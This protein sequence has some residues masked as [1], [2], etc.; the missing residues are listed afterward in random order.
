MAQ[1]T[2]E[3]IAQSGQF[4]IGYRTDARP[5]SFEEAGNATG[6]AVDICRRVALG[7]KEHLKLAEMTVTYVPV[8]LDN[9]F[10]AVADGDIDIECADT[11]ITMQRQERVD[12]SMMTFVTGGTV[13]SM[14][15]SRIGEMREL[16]RKRVAA[17]RGTS[18]ADGLQAYLS[19]NRID[20]KIT[21]VAD[22][23]AGVALLRSGGVDAFASDQILL[24]GDVLKALEKDKNVDFAFAD[25]LFSFEPYGLMVR[26]N[27]ADFR[28]VV[29]RVIAQMFRAG[30]QTKLYQ[31][32]VG[33]VGV[34]PSSLLLSMFQLQSLSE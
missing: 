23:D 12:F 24:L 9:R 13:L 25:E 26:R 2:L 11:T 7:V 17:V 3:H 31:T 1:G 15:K 8:T 4:R 27:D 28:L 34:R 19:K 16:A 33:S 10:D 30:E 22:E 6:Y 29:N 18:T 20:A 14:A 21:L 5:L 32:W